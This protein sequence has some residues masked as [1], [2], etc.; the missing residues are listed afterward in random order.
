MAPVEVGLGVVGF[1]LEGGVGIGDG[2]GVFFQLELGGGA[3]VPG[4]GVLRVDLQGLAEIGN[5]PGVVLIF[6]T[7]AAP[8]VVGQ[9][10]IGFPGQVG[11][12]VL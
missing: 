2:I 1:Q 10:V 5:G 6:E 11:I 7:G 3:V 8:V 4:V 9:G 12:V